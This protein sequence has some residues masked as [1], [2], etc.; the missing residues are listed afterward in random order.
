MPII[1]S[2]ASDSTYHSR[3]SKRT[4][5]RAERIASH[6]AAPGRL[7]DVGCNNGITSAYMLDAGKAREV[8]GIELHAETVERALREH[9]AFTLL[10]GNVVEL[11]LGGQYDHVIYGAV[12]HHILNLFGLS[13]LRGYTDEER[14]L[15]QI[16]D[17]GGIVPRYDRLAARVRRTMEDL[18]S[19]TEGAPEVTLEF[20]QGR[21]VELA[22]AVV[23]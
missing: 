17:K 15:L 7:L 8:T 9:E 22:T 19:A 14:A 16:E 5:A 11:D 13:G 23:G 4:L 10:E 21:L 12:H 18:R 20:G 1:D 2:T 6:I 3:H